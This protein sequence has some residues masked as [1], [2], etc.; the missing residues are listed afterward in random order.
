MHE[1]RTGGPVPPAPAT[2][3]HDVQR[4]VLLELVL[5]P[6]PHTDD[7]AELAARIGVPAADVDAALA[8]LVAA[9]LAGRD[10]RL[11]WA[12]TAARYCEA[13]YRMCP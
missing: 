1:Q 13:L 6:P 5:A 3:A 9:G 7:V 2:R 11:A 8:A 12:S 4:K 10:E